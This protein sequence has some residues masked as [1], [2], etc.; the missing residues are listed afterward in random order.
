MLILLSTGCFYKSPLE[1]SF[2]IA[3]ACGFD[4]VEL[5]LNDI[6][7]LSDAEEKITSLS[8][9]SN[10]TVFHAPF[11]VDSS[12]ERVQSL[13]RS[14]ELAERLNVQTVVFH[15]P[16]KFLLDISYWRWFWKKRWFDDAKVNLCVENMPYMKFGRFRINLYSIHKFKD[17]KDLAQRTP[18]K[19]A[20]D[21]THCGT[22]GT[23]LIEAFEELGGIENVYHIHLSD[24][25]EEKGVFWEHLFPGEGELE[26][27][28]FL[29]YLKD[30]GY[31][32]TITIE[33]FSKYLP[34]DD[35]EKIEKLRALLER[36]RSL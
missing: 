35:R 25:K 34:E 14:V 24:F 12:K 22:S 13:M 2:Y 21:T 33:I 6:Y 1:K 5:I 27:F 26:I 11:V 7:Y 4:G 31:N 9:I 30:V 17:L 29:C 18:L 28:K 16:L 15:P 20:F 23:N 32:R 19:I 3:D 8:R 10:I 36:I